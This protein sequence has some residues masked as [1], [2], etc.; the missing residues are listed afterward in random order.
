MFLGVMEDPSARL[1]FENEEGKLKLS[2]VDW[3]SGLIF[4]QHD[5]ALFIYFGCCC[6]SG[7]Q[8]Q[9]LISTFSLV[10]SPGQE[11]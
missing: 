10:S 9:L 1:C 3:I 5:M 2:S 7:C 4:R 6:C 11:Q 8:V